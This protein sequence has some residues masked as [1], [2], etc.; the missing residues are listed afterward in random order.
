MHLTIFCSPRGNTGWVV[1]TKAWDTRKHLH[2][3]P[4]IPLDIDRGASVYGFS[5]ASLEEVSALSDGIVAFLDVFDAATTVYF[6]ILQ[7]ST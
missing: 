7:G 4:I 5:M 6:M 1:R 3:G 2:G